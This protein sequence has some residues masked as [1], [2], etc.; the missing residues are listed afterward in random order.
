M[1]ANLYNQIP[2]SLVRKIP[3]GQTVVYRLTDIKPDP[4]N[5][6]EYLIP[7]NKNVPS[8]DQ[9]YDPT[10]DN[11]IPIAYITGVE[12]NGEAKFG[13]IFF[14]KVNGGCLI[15]KSSNPQHQKMYQYLELCNWNKSNNNRSTDY[16]TWFEKVDDQEEA[17]SS[18]SERKI[19][20]NAL[21]TADALDFN[22]VRSIA[23]MLGFKLNQSED[24]LRDLVED[25]A[26]YEP[27][28]FLSMVEQQTNSAEADIRQAVDL[29]ILKHNKSSAKFVW[30]DTKEEVF[31]YK[32]RI[33]VK[34]FQE[35]AEHLLTE[36]KEM[37]D[38]IKSRLQ[39]ERDNP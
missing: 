5:E 31:T 25:Y 10:T 21:R 33:G 23:A 30:V 32:K 26:G 28:K 37:Y 29:Q 39:T 13:N 11:Y 6:G 3:R 38:A 14:Q 1:K 4:F 27:E 34:P 15:L 16:P 18:R 7:L 12:A 19:I 17:K 8:T 35:F 9:T 22:Q 36:N 2:D 20:L 24:E